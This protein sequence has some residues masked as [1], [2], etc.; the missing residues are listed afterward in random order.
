MTG[1]LGENVILGFRG[2]GEVQVMAGSTAMS[3]GKKRA[4][5]F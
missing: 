3:M 4:K 1:R 2:G 5:I